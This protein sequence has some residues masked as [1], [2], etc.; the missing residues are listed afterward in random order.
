MKFPTPVYQTADAAV[1]DGTVTEAPVTEAAV[2]PVADPAP[3]PVVEAPKPDKKPWFLERISQESAK[4]QDATRR[5]AEAERR[6]AEA[7]A[8]A[9]R[10]QAGKDPTVTPQSAGKTFTQAEIRAEAERLR[11]HEDTVAVRD[12][13]LGQFGQ[14]FN[15]TLS[16]LNAVG[17]T[18]DDFVSDVLAVDKAGAHVLLDRLAK[19]PEKAVA[20]AGMTSRQRIAELTRM[21]V[22]K[23]ESEPKPTVPAKAVSKAPP[24]A[25]KI[26]PSAAKARDGYADDASDDEF[27][28]QFNERMKARSAR[29]G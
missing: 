15:E 16:V 7:E 25:P 17:A 14:S 5:L 22:A 13:G 6:A 3:E 9:A 10:L 26:E 12:A 20:L 11:F 19:D 8:L 24:P 27:T 28:R 21:S 4:A 1:S 23:T 29:R 2:I 18:N